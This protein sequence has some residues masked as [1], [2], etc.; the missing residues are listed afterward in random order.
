MI[1]ETMVCTKPSVMSSL[2]HDLNGGVNSD[3]PS[4]CSP[5]RRT[6]QHGEC[7]RVRGVHHVVYMLDTHMCQYSLFWYPSQNQ[8]AALWRASENGET[9]IVQGL[10]QGG[11]DPNRPDWVRVTYIQELM[12]RELLPCTQDMYCMILYMHVHVRWFGATCV[13]TM[14]TIYHRC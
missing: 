7:G 9:E 10:L 14:G 3:H 13:H 11:A 8:Q 1:R 4:S 6:A 12:P 5:T 2:L